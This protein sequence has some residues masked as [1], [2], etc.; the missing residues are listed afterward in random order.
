M[1][2]KSAVL[3]D[4]FLPQET[5]DSISARV[6]ESPNYTSG[7]VADYVRD[8]LWNEVTRIVFDRL[9]SIGLYKESF[10]TDKNITNFSYNQFRPSNYY[11]GYAHGPHID[12]GSYVFYIHPHWD[13]SWDGK[14]KITEAV[15]SQYRDGIFAKPNR[16][17]WMNPNV[18]HDVS[19][20]SENASHSRV[21]NLGFLNSCFDINPSG[22]EYINIFTTH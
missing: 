11:H 1:S 13:E 8:D 14:L 6:S 5:F 15:D 17:I 22:V 10:E 9:K 20:T 19:T 21:T 12:N 4:N 2:I 7:K 3:I 16:F 18:I